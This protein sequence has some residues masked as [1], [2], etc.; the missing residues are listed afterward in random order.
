M[1]QVFVI[2]TASLD[3]LHIRMRIVEAV[4][5]AGLY[6]ALAAQRAGAQVGLYAPR[7]HVVPPP[8]QAVVDRVQ[9]MG[10]QVPLDALPRL[11]IA[12]PGGGRATLLNASWGAEDQLLPASMPPDI[13]DAALVHIA[14]LSTAQRQLAFVRAIRDM[15][16]GRPQ[17]RISVGTYARLAYEDTET[18]RC[19]WSLAD[20]FFMNENE[21]NGLFGPVEQVHGKPDAL[22]FVTLGARGVRVIEGQ[23]V[24]H[25]EGCDVQEVDPTGAGDT[26]CGATLAG[27]AHGA[28]PVAAA[29]YAVTL[30]AQ[31]VQA[32]GPTALL[33]DDI[34]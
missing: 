20:L 13:H 7:P 15:R 22:L 27:L 1:P 3:V 21:A 23:N 32:I 2:G 9:W 16:Q 29:A 12:H 4:G 30:A 31:T 18:V 33:D 28:T 17:P 25:I 5:G 34:L 19:L 10:P 26:F 14:A 8:L 11:E 24:T 6:T